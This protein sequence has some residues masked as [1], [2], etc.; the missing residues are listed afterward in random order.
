MNN[1][2]DGDSHKL[3]ECKIGHVGSLNHYIC[4]LSPIKTSFRFTSEEFG[5]FQLSLELT[6][7]QEMNG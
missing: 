5:I 1:K 2:N 7:L 4:G 6:E 3:E